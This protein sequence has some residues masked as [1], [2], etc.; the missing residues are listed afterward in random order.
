MAI[1]GLGAFYGDSEDMASNF[2]SEGVACIG[3][4]RDDAAPLHSMMKH[5]KVGDIIYIK[6]HPP[7]QGLTI[8]AVGIVVDDKVF[9]DPDLGQACVRVRWFWHGSEYIG[10]LKDRYPVRNITLY[11][12]YN[13]SIQH[14]VI[15]L[16][17][18]E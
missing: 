8:K 10:K 18:L 7:A 2:L 17:A 14:R 9:S 5:I 4:S 16:L 3:W 12:E 1:F 15:E 11:E 6:A 13:P